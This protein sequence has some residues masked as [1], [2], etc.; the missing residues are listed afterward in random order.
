[1]NKTQFLAH[2]VGKPFKVKMKHGQKT[3]EFTTLTTGLLAEIDGGKVDGAVML[4]RVEQLTDKQIEHIGNECLSLYME[5]SDWKIIRKLEN[6]EIVILLSNGDQLIIFTDSTGCL[7]IYK[8]ET[9]NS[10]TGNE[11]KL[12]PY[13][14]ENGFAIDWS[15]LTIL[16]QIEKGFI[17][18]GNKSVHTTIGVYKD[19]SM[20][21]NGVFD[22]N[23]P[24]ELIA[25]TPAVPRDSSHLMIV[26]KKNKKIE[27]PKE[28]VLVMQTFI[29]YYWPKELDLE[30]S[31]KI[32][33]WKRQMFIKP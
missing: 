9:K 16:Q 26:D 1:M 13:Y 7:K 5:K 11:M 30:S 17:I 27:L 3:E 19:G 33:F 6:D 20:K 25:Q 23:L 24:E 18:L 10:H 4:K 28:S 32:F 31:Q 22:Y 15:E 14:I 2:Y 21:I 12:V 29:P 8:D